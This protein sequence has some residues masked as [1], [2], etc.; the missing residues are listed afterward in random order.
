MN[1]GAIG[2]IIG[3]EITHGF[4]DQGKQF[5]ENGNLVDWWAPST[6]EAY[7]EKARCI[8]E[9]YGNFTE[10]QTKLNL[11]GINTQGE[12]IA[13]NGGIKEAY[14]AYQKH[15]KE[16]GVEKKLPGLNYNTN[17]L[18]WI[19]SAQTWCASF[20]PEAMKKRILTGVHSPNQFR[21]L[22]PFSNMKEF[23][24]DFK[25]AKSSRMNPDKKCE[26]W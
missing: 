5:N 16:H 19:S 24:E 22:G 23:S 17:Q 26:V 25:C 20:R 7:L 3:H 6:S 13:D 11:N 14:L 21:V 18:F 10:Q 2:S 4:D 15:T 12:N 8:I 9:Q 1:F